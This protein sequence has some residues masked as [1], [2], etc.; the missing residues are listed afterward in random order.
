LEIYSDHPVFNDLD[1]FSSKR[2]MVK[3]G[4]IRE[5]ESITY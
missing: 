2:I 3:N 1:T 4:K 5:K